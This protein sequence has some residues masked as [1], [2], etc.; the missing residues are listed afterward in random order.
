MR[1]NWSTLAAWVTAILVLITWS[2]DKFG[3]SAE[4]MEIRVQVVETK[5]AVLE[6]TISIKLDNIGE[7]LRM[8]ERKIK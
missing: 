1:V 6:S 4:A 5:Y 3:N 8:I 2:F 7:R